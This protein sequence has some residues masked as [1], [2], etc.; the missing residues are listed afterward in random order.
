MSN[1]SDCS[2]IHN[3]NDKVKGKVVGATVRGR[4]GGQVEFYVADS[5][6]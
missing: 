5:E 3:L 4:G 1:F 2:V 6:G